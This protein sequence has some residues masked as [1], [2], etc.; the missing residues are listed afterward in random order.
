M[1]LKNKPQ[2]K[3]LYLI[4]FLLQYKLYNYEKSSFIEMVTLV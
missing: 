2:I 3:K 4:F 1:K